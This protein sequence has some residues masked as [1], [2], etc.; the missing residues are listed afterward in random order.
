MR[1]EQSQDSTL[2][3]SYGQTEMTKEVAAKIVSAGR[4]VDTALSD[5]L[6]AMQQAN[7]K[8]PK[9]VASMAK[10]GLPN[11]MG[12][13]AN[14][15]ADCSGCAEGFGRRIDHVTEPAGFT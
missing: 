4:A 1:K 8:D 12:A 13:V 3:N 11:R 14:R 7:R 2:A 9:L 5:L 10:Y 6:V 15:F